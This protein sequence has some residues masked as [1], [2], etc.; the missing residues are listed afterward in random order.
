MKDP[1]IKPIHSRTRWR[2]IANASERQEGEG[3]RSQP[4]KESGSNPSDKSLD[5][6]EPLATESSKPPACPKKFEANLGS[7]S[8]DTS[9]RV[10][11]QFSRRKFRRDREKKAFLFRFIRIDLEKKVPLRTFLKIGLPLAFI[12]GL[13]FFIIGFKSAG[14]PDKIDLPR[15]FTALTPEV[16]ESVDGIFRDLQERKG[17][18]ALEKARRLRTMAPE[19]LPALILAANAAIL[20]KDL[21]FADQNCLESL[22]KRESESDAFMLQAVV[23]LKRLQD[24]NYKP[25]GS[26]MIQ[27]E[28]LLRDAIAAAP[29]DGNP[30]LLLAML[31]RSARQSHEALALLKSSRLR[32]STS[33]DTIV[34][35]AAINLLG[36]EMTMD[37]DLPPLTGEVESSLLGMIDSAYIGMRLG[38]AKAATENLRRLREILPPKVFSQILDDPAFNDYAENPQFA[39][40]FQTQ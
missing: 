22:S 19:F 28:D 33:C 4:S 31:K 20:T 16:Q 29:L 8:D 12:V 5:G 40:F 11:Y 38:N 13:A 10:D 7:R 36:L 21:D 37:G 27:V 39:D 17:T 34:V 14:S 15:T 30:Y 26:P 23:T 18:E 32:L 2:T 24:K 25:M 9:K 3:N 6:R 35:D 1:G